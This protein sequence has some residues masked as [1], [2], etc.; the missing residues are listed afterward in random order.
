MLDFI[1]NKSLN[2][3]INLKYLGLFISSLG[4]PVPIEMVIS[5]LATKG[6]SIY[7]IA[8]ISGSGSVLGY[9]FPYLLGYIFTIKNPD[10]WLG[11]RARFLRFDKEKIEKSRK[12]IIKG[13]FFYITLTRFLPWLRVAASMAA[14]FFRVNIFKHSLA[15]FIG[16]F[17]Y[18]LI[19][20][21][22]GKKVEGDLSALITYLKMSDKWLIVI[23][24]TFAI[25]YLG[26]RLRKQIARLIIKI[27]KK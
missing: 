9:L 13:S 20:A 15:V 26:F 21:Y 16:M 23:V 10:T 8:L 14:G 11:G 19:I 24:L 1:L 25:I 3:L 22:I 27:S 12:R 17:T 4:F 18:S 5:V 6:N 2:L 7:K